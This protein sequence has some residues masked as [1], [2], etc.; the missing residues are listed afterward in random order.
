MRTP[1]PGAEVVAVC[2]EADRARACG[3]ADL[4][5]HRRCRTPRA[6]CGAT[7][8]RAALRPA[9]G[10]P[11]GY[12]FL[13]ENPGSWRVEAAGLVFVGVSSAIRR[14]AQGC[15]EAADGR[16]RGAGGAGLPGEDQDRRCWPE[17]GR[18]ATRC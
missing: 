2:S 15:G 8:R 4:R 11:S 3:E 16:G 14:W 17:A 12:G 1:A 10:D 6:T 9:R 5:L 7:H 18:S 13:S